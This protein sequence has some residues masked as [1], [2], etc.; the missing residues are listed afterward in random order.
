LTLLIAA[1]NN[2]FVAT[3]VGTGQGQNNVQTTG[4]EKY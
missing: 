1:I 2:N 3:S 4:L